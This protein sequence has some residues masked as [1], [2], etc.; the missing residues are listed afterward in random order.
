MDCR[1]IEFSPIKAQ[2]RID[3]VLRV[4]PKALLF[5]ILAFS[6]YLIGAKLSQISSLVDMPEESIRTYVRAVFRDGFDALLDRRRK[7][8]PVVSPP[9]QQGISLRVERNWVV[10][11]CD[12]VSGEIKIPI[13][14]KVQA[15]TVLLTLVQSKLLTSQNIAPVLGLSPRTCQQLAKK[16]LANDVELSLFDKRRGQTQD[17]RVGPVQKAEIIKHYAARVVTGHS[18]SSDKI[19]EAVNTNSEIAISPR[20]LR[21]HVA[22]LGLPFIKPSL[23]N[24]VDTLKKTPEPAS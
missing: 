8:T 4:F 24:M 6:L 22:K 18:T 11:S 2:Q 9:V 19:A 16:L 12:S 23:P 20:T 21:W 13:E 7:G 1:T 5:R 17:F 14:H 15:R 10:I 3:K